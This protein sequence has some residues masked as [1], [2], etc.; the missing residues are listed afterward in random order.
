MRSIFLKEINTFF[1]S[2]IGYIAVGVFLLAT[3][4][5]MWVFPDTSIID[6]GYATLDQLFSIA[7]NIFLFL[8][9]AITMRSFAEEQQSGTMELL[10]TR[11]LSDAAII[12]GKF[13]A[14]V[15]L[16]GVALVPTLLYYVSV[17]TLGDPVG[18]IDTGAVIGSYV[19]LMLL[20]AAFTAIG[21]FA[22][23]LVTNQIVA[24]LMGMMLC[25]GLYMG[26]EYISKLPFGIGIEDKI[27]LLGMNAHYDALGRGNILL[28]DI[29]Y[30]VSVIIFFLALTRYQLQKRKF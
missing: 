17:Y 7:P 4:L 8:I 22:S 10:A 25:F 6:Y 24:F 9:P 11:P 30:F 18:N 20:A 21:V 27:A 19:G 26:F 1:S 28:A 3:G 23:S 5:F 29:V 16:V 2:L 12:G 14:S 13:W 15:A